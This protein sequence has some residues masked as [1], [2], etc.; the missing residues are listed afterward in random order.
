MPK[1]ILPCGYA[2][3]P[4]CTTPPVPA[5]TDDPLIVTCDSDIVS[6]Y[7]QLSPERLAAAEAELSRE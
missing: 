5:V 1:P 7:H 6:L 2:D 4:P 3:W